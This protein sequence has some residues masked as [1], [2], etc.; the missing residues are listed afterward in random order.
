MP[1]KASDADEISRIARE[2]FGWPRL[3][4]G[5]REAIEAVLAGRDTLV[6]MPTGSGKSAVY[7]VAAMLVDGPTVVVSPLI[8]L[9]RDQVTHLQEHGAEAAHANSSVKVSERE[10]A[11]SSLRT[12]D[13]E[14]LFLAPEQFGNEETLALLRE[15]RPALFVV[16]E[17]HCISAWGHDFRPDYQRLGDVIEQLD[18]PVVIGLTATAAPPVRTEIVERLGLRDPAV[19]VRG[20]ERPNLRLRVESFFEATAEEKDAAVL[21][22]AAQ[23]ATDDGAGIVYVAT[24]KRSEQ[25]ADALTSRGV[26]AAA[27]HAGLPRSTRDDVHHRFLDGELGVVVATTAFGMGIDKP[28]VRFVLHADVAES[29]DAYYQEIGRAGRDGA[30]AEAVLFY[31]PADLS[32]R[33]FFAGGSLSPEDVLTVLHATRKPRPVDLDTIAQRTEMTPRK[34]QR[35]VNKLVDVGAV[36]C[37]DE[38]RARA[39][40]GVT[41]KAALKAVNDQEDSRGDFQRSRI[42]M[43]RSYAET[44]GCRGRFVLTYFGE[45]SDD[46]CGHCDNCEAGRT[47]DAPAESAG[48]FPAGARVVHGEWGEGQVLRA[49]DDVLVVLFDEAGYRNLSVELVMA[50]DL[51]HPLPPAS[52]VTT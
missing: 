5:Q 27:Y 51:L 48:P 10:E 35:I 25:L 11:F 49:E 7:Q 40:K 29:I 22:C 2:V 47:D 18:H 42:E 30:P 39:V 46:P 21:D 9:Q 15:A 41:G 32:I 28:D 38:G 31:R 34:V 52:C 14:F 37:D 16:D 13:L 36:T 12:G 20:F 50:N 26:E 44:R 24:Q 33:R 6:V 23:L 8:A 19:I 1:P 3:R 45:H 17:A 43:M 4:D